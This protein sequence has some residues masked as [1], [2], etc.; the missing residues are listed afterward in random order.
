MRRRL[1]LLMPVLL[2]AGCGEEAPKP[3]PAPPSPPKTQQQRA[4]DSTEVS[5]AVGYDGAAIKR[6]V[7]GV[8]DAQEKHNADNAA[9]G[10]ENTSGQ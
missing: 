9:A 4:I 1:I 5:S 2:L 8:V 3:A 7:Q 6:S 10:V